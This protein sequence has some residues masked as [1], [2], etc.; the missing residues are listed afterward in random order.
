[1]KLF[2]FVRRCRR[3]SSA[4]VDQAAEE[5]PAAVA[6]PAEK[7]RRRPSGPAWKPTLGAISEDAAVASSASAKAKPA[8]RTKAKAKGKA[9][10]RRGR[11]GAWSGR[12][13]TTSGEFFFS[14]S[15]RA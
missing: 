4:P 2:A 9:A 8:A 6:P 1:M 14:F 5:E 13:T 10:A 7:R 12:S 15:P 3:L 11:R